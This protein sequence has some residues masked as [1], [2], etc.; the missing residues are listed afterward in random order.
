[1]ILSDPVA[2]DEERP[3]TKHGTLFRVPHGRRDCKIGRIL[4][5]R[6]VMVDDGQAYDSPSAVASAFGKSLS[7]IDVMLPDPD[8]WVRLETLNSPK[9]STRPVWRGNSRI[10]VSHPAHRLRRPGKAHNVSK[11]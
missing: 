6:W 3:W 1:M 4:N 10:L 11:H 2:A 5:R 8:R 7:L 9:Y